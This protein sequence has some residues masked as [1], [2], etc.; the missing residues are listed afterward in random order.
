MQENR[1]GRMETIIYDTGIIGKLK[2][3]GNQR[4]IREIAFLRDPFPFICFE[5]SGL[6]ADEG[7]VYNGSNLNC[8]EVAPVLKKACRQIQEYLEE[9]REEFTFPI[10]MEGTRFQEDVWCA[11][12]DIPY[13]ETRTYREIAEAAGSPKAWRA[14]GIAANHN[15]L[16]LVIPCHRVIGSRGRLT[17]YN[18]GLD[19]KEQ[20]LI[21][22]SHRMMQKQLDD[23]E[24]KK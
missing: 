23:R 5:G 18:G 20:L 6:P 16:P 4:E 21:I 12:L 14:V 2:I 7:P 15:R 8:A 17:G 22:E 19:I 10:R 3:K 24:E 13:G 11:M 9:E 1:E